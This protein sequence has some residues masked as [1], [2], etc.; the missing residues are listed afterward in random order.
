LKE[1]INQS[2]NKTDNKRWVRINNFSQS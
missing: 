2:I 1:F